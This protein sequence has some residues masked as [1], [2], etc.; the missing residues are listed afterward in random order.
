LN[1][2]LHEKVK[3]LETKNAKLLT[4]CGANH[5]TIL[6]FTQGKENLNRLLSTQRASFNK[7]SIGYDHFN[8]KKNYKNFFVKPTLHEMNYCSKDDHIALEN[9][10]QRSFKYGFLK[11]QDHL[12]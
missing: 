10:L 8:K 4:K 7:E 6:K 11:E 5:K 3:D 9:P 2:D 12:M 1:N